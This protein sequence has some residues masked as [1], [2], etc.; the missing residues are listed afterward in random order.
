MNLLEAIQI[1]LV[2]LIGYISRDI[3]KLIENAKKS[4]N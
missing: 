3:Y 4:T 2:F 1:L